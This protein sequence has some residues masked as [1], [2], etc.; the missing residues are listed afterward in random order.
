MMKLKTLMTNLRKDESG[1]AMV[2]YTILLGI[3]AA[4]VVATVILVGSW[5]STKWTALEALL[6]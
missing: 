4:A 2:E 6:P 1:A 3:L 5:L